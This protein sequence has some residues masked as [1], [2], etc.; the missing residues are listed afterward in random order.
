[1]YIIHHVF[2]NIYKM[3]QKM[4]FILLLAKKYGILYAILF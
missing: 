3:P 4:D 1:M 2:I